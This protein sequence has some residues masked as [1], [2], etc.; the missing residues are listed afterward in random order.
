MI[1]RLSEIL[2]DLLVASFSEDLERNIKLWEGGDTP[3][4][5]QLSPREDS[6]DNDDNQTMTVSEIPPDP[7]FCSGLIV[8]G[9]IGADDENGGN[10]TGRALGSRG[11]L[12]EVA[13]GGDVDAVKSPTAE[14]WE[15][16][17][18]RIFSHQA[19][20]SDKRNLALELPQAGGAMGDGGGRR[21]LSIF[22]G[23]EQ[24]REGFIGS[25][26]KVRE[27]LLHLT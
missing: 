2:P 14:G 26:Y 16:A 15:V 27:Q 8:A 4:P 10:S 17:D 20:G 11:A 3:P 21:S 25:H 7:T 23:Y 18:S 24:M 22:A 1:T 9:Q 6:R 12:N 5:C 19:G 13:G